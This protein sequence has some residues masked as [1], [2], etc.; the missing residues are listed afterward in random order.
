MAPYGLDFIEGVGSGSHIFMFVAGQRQELPAV[1]SVAMAQVEKRIYVI[2]RYQVLFARF[3]I[4]REHDKKNLIVEKPVLEM[5][6]KRGYCGV[7][8]LGNRGALLEIERKNREPVSGGLDLGRPS[9]EAQQ[10]KKLPAILFA[11]A[12]VG[13][14]RINK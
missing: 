5:A 6:V 13:Q 9:R 14:E 7:I 2:I 12:V 3:G 11:I 8:L 4:E 1:Q 10:L